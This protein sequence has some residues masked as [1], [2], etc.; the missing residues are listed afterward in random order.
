MGFILFIVSVVLTSILTAFSFIYELIRSIYKVR[1]VT[2]LKKI[3]NWF[4]KGAVSIDQF[5]NGSCAGLL[6]LTMRKKGGHDFGDIDVTVSCVLGWNDNNNTLTKFGKVVVW[7]LDKLEKDHCQKAVE[8][9]RLNDIKAKDRLN[10][11][12]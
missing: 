8:F 10:E 2:G 9:Q 12:D 5:G 6:N 7:I 3:D 1:F 11:E 4:L